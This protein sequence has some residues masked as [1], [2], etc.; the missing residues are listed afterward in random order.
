MGRPKAD[1][2]GEHPGGPA[3][4]AQV[5]IYMH[6]YEYICVCTHACVYLGS[7]GASL[8]EGWQEKERISSPKVWSSAK[9]TGNEVPPY[10]HQDLEEGEK[11]CDSNRISATATSP[12]CRERPG[13]VSVSKNVTDS[14]VLGQDPGT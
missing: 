4:E 9:Q 6:V 11:V 2:I 14:V 13:S 1:G 8:P 7:S 12:V 3:T 10:A 5:G